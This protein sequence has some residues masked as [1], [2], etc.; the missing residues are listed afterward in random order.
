MGLKEMMGALFGQIPAS[1]KEPSFVPAP[2]LENYPSSDDADYARKYDLGYGSGKEAYLNNQAARVLGHI[3][4]FPPKPKDKV[5]PTAFVATSGA[6]MGLDE[7]SKLDGT[8]SKNLDLTEPKYDTIRKDIGDTYMRAALAAN[9]I[10]IAAL[11]FDPSRMNSDLMIGGS[12][13]IAGAYSPDSDSIYVNHRPMMGSTS[14]HESIHRGIELLKKANP[15]AGD[16]LR[17][18]PSD[19][20]YIVRHLMATQAGDPEAVSTGNV[21]IAQKKMAKD[22]FGAGIWDKEL[23]ELNNMAA[24]EIAKRKPGGPN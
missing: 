5:I 16:L 1:E 12:P 8:L 13:N 21:T 6:G 19:E 17:K 2:K 14:L 10:P 9:R 20:E 15:E 24:K 7:A 11:G 23:N 18:I 3:A 22:I 4:S